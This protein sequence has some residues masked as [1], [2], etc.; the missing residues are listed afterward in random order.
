MWKDYRVV[1]RYCPACW[2]DVS[3]KTTRSED[4]KRMFLG[5]K[6][7]DKAR[8]GEARTRIR[9]A[10]I[11]L[12]VWVFRCRPEPCKRGFVM[13][14]DNVA[15]N[16]IFRAQCMKRRTMLHEEVDNVAKAFL[17]TQW[18]GTL[19]ACL[20]ACLLSYFRL[21][22]VTCLCAF[23]LAMA[24]CLAACLLRRRLSCLRT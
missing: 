12:K 17:G 23:R 4:V 15:H 7:G 21:V 3:W 16:L 5:M 1:R 24:A 8:G 13:R 9:T 10:R 14:S 2:T 22:L 19:S 11:Q 18:E 20:L 6:L